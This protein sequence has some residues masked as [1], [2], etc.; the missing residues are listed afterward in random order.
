[1]NFDI[2]QVGNSPRQDIASEKRVELHL[3]TCFSVMDSC[4]APSDLI[5]QAAQWGHGAI[6]ITDHGGVQAFPEAF[7]AAK[8]V[9]VKL[10]PGCEGYIINDGAEIVERGEDVNLDS[11]AYVVLNVET[12]GLNTHTDKIIAIGAVRIKNGAEVAEFSELID[13]GRRVPEHAA[14]ITGINRGVEPNAQFQKED[15]LAFMC[16]EIILVPLCRPVPAFVL[17]KGIV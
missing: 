8:N 7:A 6:A 16:A 3:H 13:P 14:Q 9:G 2:L 12:T 11:A 15:F 17:Y 10:I 5:K 1:M 4:A